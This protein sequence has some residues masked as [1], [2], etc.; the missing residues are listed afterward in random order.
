MLS[1]SSSQAAVV[2]L[3]SG[4]GLPSDE[5]WLAYADDSAISGGS[6]T[7]T[8]VSGGVRLVTDNTVMSGYSNYAGFTHKNNA[9][10][11]LDR[12]QGFELAFT[13]RINAE[14]HLN[15]HRAGF[16]VILLGSDRRGVELGFWGDE[17]WAQRETP[18]F[19]HGEGVAVDTTVTRNYRL[20]IQGDDYS[21]LADAN[22]LLNGQIKDYTAFGLPPYTLSNF[23]FLGDDTSSASADVLLG[24]VILQSNLSSV[25]EPSVASL[26]CLVLGCL[27][28]RRRRKR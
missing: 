4:V 12:S 20:R 3:Y 7:Q 5:A 2:N 9:F 27:S 6:A 15:N 23:V 10:P 11:S 25:P 14:S 21:L 19:T 18:L 1:V 22:P 24:P 28:I 16:S 17:I 8:V 13:A 26:S